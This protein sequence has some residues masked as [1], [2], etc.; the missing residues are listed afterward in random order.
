MTDDFTEI[1]RTRLSQR[2]AQRAAQQPAVPQPA[3]PIDETPSAVRSRRAS[4][5]AQPEASTGRERYRTRPDAAV[6]AVRTPGTTP[7]RTPIDVTAPDHA[8]QQRTVRTRA[9]RRAVWLAAGILIL[10]LLVTTGIL[11][12]TSALGR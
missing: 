3:A 2:A 8:A 6:R 9:R 1:S 12:V 4:A 7:A 11:L 10:L 5:P